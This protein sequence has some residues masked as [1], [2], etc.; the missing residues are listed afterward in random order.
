MDKPELNH[1]H[2]FQLVVQKSGNPIA[3]TCPDC[4]GVWTV[5]RG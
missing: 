1:K 3:L 5:R 4:G 2:K